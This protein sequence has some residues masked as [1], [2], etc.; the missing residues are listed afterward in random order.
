MNT[1]RGLICISIVSALMM[2]LSGCG[3]NF[4]G[5]SEHIAYDRTIQNAQSISMINANGDALQ[6]IQLNGS[7]PSLRRDGQVL[8]FVRDGDIYTITSMR[9]DLTNL[10]N[11]LVGV[12]ASMPAFNPDG[13]KIAYVMEPVVPSPIPS[14]HIMNSDGT[15]DTV[16]VTNG[17]SPSFS[18]DGSKI[19]FVRGSDLYTIKIDGSGLLNITNNMEGKILDSPVF[20]PDGNT[21]YYASSDATTNPVVWHI[22]ALQISGGSSTTVVTDGSYPTISPD[23]TKMAFVRSKKVFSIDI[24]GRN[25]MQLTFGEDAGNPSWSL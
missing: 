10:T 11:N 15:D 4:H 24:S 25:L 12:G 2:A 5:P 17:K 3:N 20:S 19:V 9:T 21:I 18:P 1:I 6:L 23:G 16:V 22:L 14:I 7:D 8:A 13:T